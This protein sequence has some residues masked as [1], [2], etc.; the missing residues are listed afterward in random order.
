MQSIKQA[1]GF[2]ILAVSILTIPVH[3]EDDD[4]DDYEIAEMK[5]EINEWLSSD[6]GK[7]LKEFVQKE[8]S[9]DVWKIINARI[10]YE[11]WKALEA[12][13]YLGEI[14]VE[15][16]EILPYSR[17]KA[18]KFLDH[19]RLEVESYA[20]AENIMQ[21][22]EDGEQAKEVSDLKKK[23]KGNLEKAFDSK[24]ELQEAEIKNLKDEVK[25]LESLIEKRIENRDQII[26]RRLNELLGQQDYLEW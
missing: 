19:S 22:E 26:Q 15:Y 2:F 20:L 11:P 13:E 10:E 17:K 14:M 21:L 23:L 9:N 25:E 5:A 7:G 1:L 12:L 3:A 24:I 8:F 16:Y 18:D 6:E 4:D